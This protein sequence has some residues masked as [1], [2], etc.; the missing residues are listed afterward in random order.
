MRENKFEKSHIHIMKSETLSRESRFTE[1]AKVIVNS[2]PFKVQTIYLIF[3]S[4]QH[5][6][7]LCEEERRRIERRMSRCFTWFPDCLILGKPNI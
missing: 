1:S 5:F 4:C 7:T 2:I 3:T 6:N